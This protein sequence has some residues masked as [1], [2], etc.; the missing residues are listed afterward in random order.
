MRHVGIPLAIYEMHG[1]LDTRQGTPLHTIINKA[2]L[3]SCQKD[4][5]QCNILYTYILRTR[6][7]FDVIMLFFSFFF[8][9]F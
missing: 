1:I 7:V 5:A 9:S 4:N 8:F 3:L 6:A 2:I